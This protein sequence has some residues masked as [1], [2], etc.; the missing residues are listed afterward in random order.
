GGKLVSAGPKGF[1]RVWDASSGKSLSGPL[2]HRRL[3]G[4]ELLH[5]FDAEGTF[6]SR[7]WPRFSPDGRLLTTTD[8]FRIC[9]WSAG[10]VRMPA[11]AEPPRLN[12]IESAFPPDGRYLAFFRRGPV[13]NVWLLDHRADPPR[14][15][16]SVNADRQ[17]AGLRISPDGTLLVLPITG[18]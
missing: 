18:G 17:P 6:E 16:K 12:Q 2:P 11:V 7:R 15:V 13:S 8:G 4:N 14:V 3:S 1:A 9:V 10:R 5:V